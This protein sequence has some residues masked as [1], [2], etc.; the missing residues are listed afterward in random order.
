MYLNKTKRMKRK[1]LFIGIVLAGILQQELA[2][3]QES[4]NAILNF[5]WNQINRHAK[6][7]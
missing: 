1:L 6:N 2:H 7:V 3:S 5:E 4:D